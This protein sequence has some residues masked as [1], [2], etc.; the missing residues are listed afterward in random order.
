MSSPTVISEFKDFILKGNAIS[1]AVGVIIGAA[2]GKIVE[3]ITKGI[4]EPMINLAGGNPEVS[5]KL[6]VF[7]LGMV[8]NAILA[9]LITGAVLFFVFVRPM[10]RLLKKEEAAPAAPP[11]PSAEEKLLTEIRD[12]LAKN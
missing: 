7:D 2:F 8:I 6:W 9:L 4:I 5:L 11:E 3:A 1:L 12:L 10:N